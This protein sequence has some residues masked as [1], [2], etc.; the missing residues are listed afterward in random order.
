VNDVVKLCALVDVTEGTPLRVTPEGFPPLAVFCLHGQYYVTADTC[1]HGQA[2]LCDGYLEG[3]VIECP[4]HGGAFNIKSG[5][6]TEFPCSEPIRTYP[7]HAADGYLCM[8]VV[9]GE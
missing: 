8:T 5:E 4:F 1:T 2:S 6:A 9:V 7:V 3:E